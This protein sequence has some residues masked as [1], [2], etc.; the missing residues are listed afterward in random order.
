[1]QGT[2]LLSYLSTRVVFKLDA[3]YSFMVAS[4]VMG[5]GLEVATFREARCGCSSLVY[6]VRVDL[7]GR[8]CVRCT[9]HRIVWV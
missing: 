4:C 1:M 7:I 2:F 8:D 9:E 5:L 6:R 3:S